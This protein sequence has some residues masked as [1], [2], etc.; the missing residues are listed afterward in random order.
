MNDKNI[1]GWVIAWILLPFFFIAQV[2]DSVVM[3]I[4]EGLKWK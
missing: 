1:I 4:K 3:L 2:A